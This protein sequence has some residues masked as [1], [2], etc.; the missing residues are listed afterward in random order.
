MPGDLG[1]PV[2]AQRRGPERL[3]HREPPLR[4]QAGG[5]EDAHRGQVARRGL[6][7]QQR[8]GRMGGH[9]QHVREAMLLDQAERLLGL[10]PAHEHA[11]AAAQ[12]DR[13]V[14]EDQPADEPELGGHQAAVVAAESPAPADALGGVAQRVARVHDALGRRGRARGVHDH[15]HVV[16]AALG[17]LVGRF[18][19]DELVDGLG[20]ER[21]QPSDERR[22]LLALG[23]LLLAAEADDRLRARLVG[24]RGELRDVEHRRQRREHDAAVQAAEQ[25][26]GSL[27]RVAAEQ[28]HDVARLDGGGGQARRQPDGG[29]AQLVVRDPAVVEDQGDLVGRGVRPCGE[30]APQVTG[31]PV[32]LGVVPVGVWLEAQRGHVETLVARSIC[33][34]PVIGKRAD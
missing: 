20:H 22:R 16:G 17:A 8:V 18:G 2:V 12:E 14:A 25:G 13:E 21:D 23:D 7:R 33:D 6:R 30:I 5:A 32:A 3:L 28:Q 11:R 9:Q 34:C 4:R 1:E 15:R 26:H 29:A 24:Q 31:P 27:D 10:P 19:G